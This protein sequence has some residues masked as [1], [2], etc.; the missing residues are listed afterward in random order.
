MKIV[1]EIQLENKH[2]TLTEGKSSDHAFYQDVLNIR[3]QAFLKGRFFKYYTKNMIV[4]DCD[5]Y[6]RIYCLYFKETPLG[7]VAV[8]LGAKGAMHKEHRF[9]DILLKNP[10]NTMCSIQ[11]LC[12]GI[13]KIK[14]L[15]IK[16]ITIYRKVM[17]ILEQKVK[18]ENVHTIVVS[19]AISLHKFQM[20]L[21]YKPVAGSEYKMKS[22]I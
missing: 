9:P 12:V 1:A 19:T 18:K 17:H 4:S 8:T 22:T 10:R 5:P 13:D 20:A 3:K 7:T 2:L 11:K 15:N 16:P 14:L 6:S 21:G